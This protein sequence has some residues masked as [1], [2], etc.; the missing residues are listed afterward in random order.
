MPVLEFDDPPAACARGPVQGQCPSRLLPTALLVLLAERESHGYDL[1]LRLGDLG[2]PSDLPGIY[3]SLRSMDRQGLVRSA[4]DTSPRGPARRTYALT[5]EG[6]HVLA[7]SV[8]AMEEACLNL[9]RLL[10]RSRRVVE[11]PTAL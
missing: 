10:Q 4:W 8:A 7:S 1:A 3:R 6:R 9:G 2:V 11:A 5:D